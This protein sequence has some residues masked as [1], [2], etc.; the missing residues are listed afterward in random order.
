MELK[1]VDDLSIAAKVSLDFDIVSDTSR[2]RPLTSDQRQ[3]LKLADSANTLQFM[4]D[5]LL[6]FSNQRQM[7]INTKK[8]CVM[9]I[10]KSRTIVFP[11]ELKVGEHFLE[12][13]TEMKILGVILQPNLKWGS[14]TAFMCKKAY[15][16]MWAIRRMKVLG[17]DTFTI[18]DYY[19]K[20]VRVHLELAVPVWHSGLT[21][22]L[23]ADIERVQ[24]VA[25]GILTGGVPYA[26]ACANLGL[27]PLHVR[28]LEL[29]ERFA[30]NTT[31]D[32]SRHK[33]LFKLKKNPRGNAK[34]KEHTCR[35][36]RFYKSPLPYLTRIL[37]DV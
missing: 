24:R 5:D 1:Y 30:V 13:K 29:C 20:E 22:K 9:K 18:L 16:S 3:E 33:D 35:K 25:V 34:F 36:S 17:V 19:M 37:N 14:N 31:S 32:E 15:K 28:R 6:E 21:Y 4:L 7:K 10:C 23:T 27:K 12:V 8:T 11:T 26:Q 2:E